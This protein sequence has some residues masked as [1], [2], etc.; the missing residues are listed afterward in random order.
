METSSPAAE[1]AP[2]TVEP[3]PRQSRSVKDMALS[4]LVLLVPLV[5][6]V[7]AYRLLQSGDRPVPVDPAPVVARAVAEGAFPVL[8]PVGLDAGWQPVSAVYRAEGTGSTLRLGYLAP[9]GDGLQ[10]VQSDMPADALL[11]RELGEAPRGTGTVPVN[12][13]PWQRYAA[14]AGETGLVRTGVDSTVIVIGRA[15]E[16]ELIRLAASLR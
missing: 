14:R 3:A 16:N 11:A 4:L 12:G 7:G 9:G 10:V 5:L 15:P 2:P 8:A 6:V 1:P 13:Q